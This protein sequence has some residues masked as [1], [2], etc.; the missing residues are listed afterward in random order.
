MFVFTTTSTSFALVFPSMAANKEDCE[1]D[2]FLPDEEEL[3]A[4]CVLAGSDPENCS[5]SRVRGASCSASLQ[6]SF[7]IFT[8]APPLA[9]NTYT[10]PPHVLLCIVLRV[11]F[12]ICMCC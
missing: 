7:V 8:P 5:Y 10:D 1:P 9:S 6:P 2:D 4:L 11:I 12:N 3:A